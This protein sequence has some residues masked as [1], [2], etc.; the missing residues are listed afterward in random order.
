MLDEFVEP[1]SRD[2]LHHQGPPAVELNQCVGVDDAGMPNQAEH[3]RFVAQSAHDVFAASDIG[4]EDLEGHGLAK[5][6]GAHQLCAV[7]RAEAAL[8][9]HLD[10]PVAARLGYHRTT[11]T[12]PRPRARA[13]VPMEAQVKPLAWVRSA[14]GFSG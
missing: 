1:Y 13:P 4:V 2:V 12:V 7:D 11:V 6:T 14:D 9:Q 10:D 5:A 8:S 3:S